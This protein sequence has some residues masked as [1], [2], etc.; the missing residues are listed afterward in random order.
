M[1]HVPESRVNPMRSPNWPTRPSQQ[2]GTIDRTTPNQQ[3]GRGALSPAAQGRSATGKLG[4]RPYCRG[5]QIQQRPGEVVLGDHDI[6]VSP[7]A[8]RGEGLAN[9]AQG[10]HLVGR[11][12]LR[13]ADR[14]PVV[15]E[16]GVVV[17]LDDDRF[18]ARGP[19]DKRE[20]PFV[21]RGIG[22]RLVLG[23][24]CIQ[25]IRRYGAAA[26]GRF[27]PGGC[28]LRRLWYRWRSSAGASPA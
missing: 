17:V 9:R 22:G 18:S 24:R 2:H 21:R 7:A 27:A 6:E 4:V 14:F 5:H 12:P 13:G 3:P 20:P 8:T 26:L 25:V 19:V 23:R 11:E 28:S 10:D 15:A 1:Y 16:L